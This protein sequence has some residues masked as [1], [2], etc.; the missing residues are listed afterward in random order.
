MLTTKLTLL[1][2]FPLRSSRDTKHEVMSDSALNPDT[3]NEA[4]VFFSLCEFYFIFYPGLVGPFTSL[5]PGL[6]TPVSL[7]IKTALMLISPGRPKFLT[8]PLIGLP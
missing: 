1:L 6:E 7:R 5:G 2:W 4:G 3:T 8:L